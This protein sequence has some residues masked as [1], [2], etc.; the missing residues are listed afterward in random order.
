M[1]QRRRD[2]LFRLGGGF[3]AAALSQLLPG[4]L[5]AA[6]GV[7]SAGAEAAALSGEGE[8]RHLPFYAWR[9]KPR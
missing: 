8:E 2:M 9:R 7:K 6:P 1:E 5:F 4:D 3:G